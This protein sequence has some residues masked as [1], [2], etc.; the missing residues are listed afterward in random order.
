MG[1]VEAVKIANEGFATVPE[2][3]EVVRNAFPELQ[4]RAIAV[5]AENIRDKEDI[6]LPAC[7][8][9]LFS[10]LP[11]PSVVLGSSGDANLQDDYIIQFMFEAKQYTRN[12]AAIPVWSYYDYVTVRHRLFVAL[13]DFAARNDISLRFI[14]LEVESDDIAVVLTFRFRQE[15]PWCE[16]DVCDTP[17]PVNISLTLTGC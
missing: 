13:N 14:S 12:N 6:T 5:T 11:S 10:S 3:A 9:S 15:F 1:S 17:E 4:G 7:L 8:L 2:V 16:D